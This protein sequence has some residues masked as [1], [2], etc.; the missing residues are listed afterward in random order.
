MNMTPIKVLVRQMVLQVLA[1]SSA[2][3][4]SNTAGMPIVV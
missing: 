1:V 2:I 4:K 3:K